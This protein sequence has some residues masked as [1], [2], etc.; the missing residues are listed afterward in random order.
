MTGKV[1]LSVEGWFRM[2]GKWQ[3][4][5]ASPCHVRAG[6]KGE[7]SWLGLFGPACTCFHHAF[8]SHAA[9]FHAIALAGHCPAVAGK[10]NLVPNTGVTHEQ[11]FVLGS[12]AYLEVRRRPGRIS[13]GAADP[14]SWGCLPRTG[15]LAAAPASCA[16]SDVSAMTLHG[17]GRHGGGGVLA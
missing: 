3:V 10:E 15:G 4:F 11:A 16:L 12:R 5:V 2:S 13:K 7:S 9:P 17:E 6:G 14:Q 1:G 8:A